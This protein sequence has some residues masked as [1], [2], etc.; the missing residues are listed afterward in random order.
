MNILV[1]SAVFYPAVGGIENQTLLLINQFIQKGHTVKVITY[2]KNKAEL[3]GVEILYAPQYLRFLKAHAWC[4]VFYMP[5]ISLKGIWLVLL[6][7]TKKWIISHNDFHFA[8]EKSLAA[9]LKR[10]C[11]R[12]TTHNIAV[13]A[14]IGRSLNTKHIVIQNCYDESVFR[15]YPEVQRVYDFV[16][17]GRLVSQ[18]GCDL[19]LKACK[20]LKQ[21]FTLGIIG[22]GPEKKY[23]ERLVA[24]YD[25]EGSVHFYGLLKNEELAMTLNRF[26]YMVIPSVKIEGFGM[27]CLEGLACGCKVIAADAAGLADAVKSYGELFEMG[28]RHQLAAL[29]NKALNQKEDGPNNNQPLQNYL[30][31]HHRSVVADKYLQVFNT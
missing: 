15:L 29:L 18:K 12:F 10:F 19:L 11:T 5:N 21:P 28:N 7:P 1:F 31:Q 8:Y 25:L 22:I 23:L 26:R 24:K 16:F 27:V 13:S 30:Q 17:L 2:Q 9:M 6:N 4:D 20:E 14:S 3:P